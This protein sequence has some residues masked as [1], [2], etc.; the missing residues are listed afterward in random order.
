MR[1]GASACNGVGRVEGVLAGWPGAGAVGD[2]NV[3]AGSEAT[4]EAEPGPVPGA[5]ASPA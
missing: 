1:V 2:F 3:E 4:G 5:P